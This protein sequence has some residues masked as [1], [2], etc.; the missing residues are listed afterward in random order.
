MKSVDVLTWHLLIASPPV[1]GVAIRIVARSTAEYGGAM[2]RSGV[3]RI[4]NAPPT[5]KVSLEA[6]PRVVSRRWLEF[7][8]GV[9]S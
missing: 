4:K 5:I 6:L 2:A 1:L 8:G 3:R 7:E 9:I